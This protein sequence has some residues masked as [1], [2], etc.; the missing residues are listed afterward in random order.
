V[1]GGFC[2]PAVGLCGDDGVALDDA[3]D[4]DAA[5]GEAADGEAADGDAADSVAPAAAAGDAAVLVAS[6]FGVE[7]V[8][9]IPAAY[10]VMCV[11]TSISL[12]RVASSIAVLDLAAPLVPVAPGVEVAV[13][14]EEVSLPTISLMILSIAATSVPQLAFGALADWLAPGRVGVDSDA[15]ALDDEPIFSRLLKCCFNLL[16]SDRFFDGTEFA[17]MSFTAAWA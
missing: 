11:R 9:A 1:D 13:D 12:A 10:A 7:G 14:D 4:G 3:V 16:R 6:V 17:E 15:L 8:P 2:E 5:D